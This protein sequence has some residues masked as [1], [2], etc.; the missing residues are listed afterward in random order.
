MAVVDVGSL[1][2]IAAMLAAARIGAAAALMNPALTP[3]EL[4]GLREN[5]GCADVGV[6]GEA[7]ADRLL[8]AVQP[9]ALTATELFGGS[10][11]S[12]A[13]A[14]GGVD[15]RDGLVLFT[16]GTTGLPKAIRITQGTLTRAHHGMT[17]CRSSR[18]PRRSSA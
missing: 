3:S 2:S 1:L 16:S 12:R 9:K 17:R 4:R 14:G 18:M 10:A 5:A 7:Y 8:E 13:A 15:D 6:A 11:G